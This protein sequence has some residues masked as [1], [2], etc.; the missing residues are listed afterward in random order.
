MCKCK[1]QEQAA[2]TSAPCCPP[3]Q[4]RIHLIVDV[5]E[6]PR[7]QRPLAVGQVCEYAR[8]KIV[9]PEQQQQQAEQQVEQQPAAASP[10]PPLP[11]LIQQQQAE[12]AEERGGGDILR[13]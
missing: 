5:A 3:L 12:D 9:C 8:G 10:P 2:L 4:P 11:P 6:T 7:P 1:C 13:R